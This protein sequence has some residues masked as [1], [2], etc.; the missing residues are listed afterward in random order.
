MCRLLFKRR[1]NLFKCSRHQHVRL[2]RLQLQ[3]LLERSGPLS[4]AHKGPAHNGP[5]LRWR[6]A[7][8]GYYFISSIQSVSGEKWGQ[9]VFVSARL[10]SRR[11]P[12]NTP[13]RGYP[14]KPSRL[15]IASASGYYTWR[16][17]RLVGRERSSKWLWSCTITSRGMVRAC[18]S[19]AIQKERASLS[20]YGTV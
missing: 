17:G 13:T 6:L 9:L 16:D 10:H 5:V 12:G 2:H 18:S 15:P 4:Y 19:P 7:L 11:C 3:F 1:V 20:T 8:R 14:L